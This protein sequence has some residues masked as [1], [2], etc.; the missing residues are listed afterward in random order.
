[1]TKSQVRFSKDLSC[2]SVPR[3]D[4]VSAVIRRIG[5]KRRTLCP[6]SHA[7]CCLFEKLKH[8]VSHHLISKEN[9]PV[10][11]FKTIFCFE[12]VSCRLL[13]R[14]ARMDMD[15]NPTFSGFFL[16]FPQNTPK[17]L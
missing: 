3:S 8:F 17:K 11:L 16:L 15:G 14:M 1:M 5:E 10:L 6:L 13:Q 9:G 4:T 2:L 7:I 12:N